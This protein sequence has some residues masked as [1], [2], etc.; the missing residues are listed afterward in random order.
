MSA[1][2]RDEFRVLVNEAARTL[3]Q[4]AVEGHA[5]LQFTAEAREPYETIEIAMVLPAEARSR[6]L[7]LAQ[8]Q[9]KKVWF[10]T[11]CMG[12]APGAR[13]KLGLISVKLTHDEYARNTL[14][15]LWKLFTIPALSVHATSS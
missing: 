14:T 15:L 10:G 6:H 1:A 5:G 8:E 7:L 3:L 12:D 11:L 4:E 2:R 13:R 9:L